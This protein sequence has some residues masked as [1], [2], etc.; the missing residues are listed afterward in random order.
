M[1]VTYGA[2][3]QRASGKFGG[4][5]HSNWKGVDV[6]RRFAKPS[7]PNSAGQ[8]DVRDAFR[9]LNAGYVTMPAET[10]AAWTSFATG[11]PFIARNQFI[12][13][14]VANLAGKVNTQLIQ[15]TPGDSS[16]LPPVSIAVTFGVGS[17][18]SAV[19]V[20]STPTGWTL[21]AAVLVAISDTDPTGGIDANSWNW[22][23][24]TDLTNPY[25]PAL[26]GLNAGNYVCGTFL[27]W[28]AP[29]GTTRYSSASNAY[30]AVA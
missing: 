10:R 5:V 13:K 19:T 17:I 18:S 28:L 14:N 21:T 16:T 6:V 25:A 8:T 2:I 20:P 9:S 30:G 27:K 1:K 15:F 24:A 7:N 23:E 26:G 4:T 3:V 11:K 22:D 29:D 12:G